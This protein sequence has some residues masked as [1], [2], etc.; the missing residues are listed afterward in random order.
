ML[1]SGREDV[2][3]IRCLES[4]ARSPSLGCE[5]HFS[6]PIEET[7]ND[8]KGFVLGL[9]DLPEFFVDLRG[10]TVSQRAR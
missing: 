4:R 8:I 7:A 10:A 9:D 2:P 5:I 6:D 3:A 1:L